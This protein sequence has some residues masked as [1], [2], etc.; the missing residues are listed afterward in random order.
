MP[1]STS[2]TKPLIRFRNVRKAFG[3]HVVLDKMS[4]DVAD[5][6]HLCI[7]GPSGSGK[8]TILRLLMTLEA[9]TAGSISI[10]G[11]L[12]WP[13]FEGDADG[14]LLRDER[15]RQ[16]RLRLQVGMVFQQFNLFPHLTVRENLMLA[17]RLVKRMSRNEVDDRARSLLD[18]VGLADKVD[19][20]P[21]DLSGG[22][23]QRVA[24]ARALAMQPR[25]MLF[26]EVTSA[27][28]PEL[29]GEVVSVIHELSRS[30][31][32]TMLFV[33]HQLHFVER[34]ADRVLVLDGGAI[35]EDGPPSRVLTEP[36]HERTQ[37][38]LAA[39]ENI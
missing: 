1:E 17:P 31:D 7:I 20:W 5:G 21:G 4:L 6:E 14:R 35:V 9:P 30:T 34:I 19:A 29:V 16:D 28:D 39:I 15:E 22:Q 3:D 27:L 37:A 26:D 23:K 32:M 10:G 2:Q 13:Q 36:Q 11:E 8:S 33:T 38:F 25:I 18:Q 12:L 24:I